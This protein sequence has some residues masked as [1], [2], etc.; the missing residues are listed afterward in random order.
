M[1]WTNANDKKRRR[2]WEKKMDFFVRFN[3]N[4]DRN[5]MELNQKREIGT[6]GPSN[7]GRSFRVFSIAPNRCPSFS[8]RI[9]FLRVPLRTM[10]TTRSE[11]SPPPQVGS[12]YPAT[13]QVLLVS[14]CCCF[15]FHWKPLGCFWFRS[16][17]L[18]NVD[19]ESVDY[20]VAL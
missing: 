14:F 11:M 9:W 4:V 6:P 15:F 12:N 5:V 10:F 8:Y 17:F 20:S 3:G 19:F 7:Q 13:F 2:K 18:Y 1:P 16:S